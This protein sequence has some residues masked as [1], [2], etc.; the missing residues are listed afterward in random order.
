VVDGD[1]DVKGLEMPFIEDAAVCGSQEMGARK[2]IT[3]LN[4]PPTNFLF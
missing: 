4:P 2:R 1:I 3:L